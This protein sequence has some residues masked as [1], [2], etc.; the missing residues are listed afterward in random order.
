MI[1]LQQEEQLKAVIEQERQ[2]L[3]M[4][5]ALEQRDKLAAFAHEEIR[6]RQEQAVNIGMNVTFA[7]RYS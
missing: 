5:L 2:Q 6:Q 1:D 3:L 4:V 7:T